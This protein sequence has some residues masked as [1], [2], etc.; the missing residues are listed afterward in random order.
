MGLK[1]G[2]ERCFE[3]HVTTKDAK[4]FYLEVVPVMQSSFEKAHE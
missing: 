2:S 3:Y 4:Q 1:C